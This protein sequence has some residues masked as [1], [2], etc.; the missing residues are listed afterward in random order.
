MLQS[1]STARY[2][3]ARRSVDGTIECAGIHEAIIT[4]TLVVHRRNRPVLVSKNSSYAQ[5]NVGKGKES[6]ACN[7]AIGL[8]ESIQAC[9]PRFD[10]SSAQG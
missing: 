10:M 2:T 6:S 1:G 9:T 3:P 8:R 7:D 5:I 4:P